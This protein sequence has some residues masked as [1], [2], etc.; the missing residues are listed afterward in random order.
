MLLRIDTDHFLRE[1]TEECK[2]SRDPQHAAYAQ[3][4]NEHGV[5]RD[6]GRLFPFFCYVPP[7]GDSTPTD[8]PM[9]E[10]V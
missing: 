2:A 9:R 3:R 5:F 7:P 6:V 10:V 8:K 1:R 4:T